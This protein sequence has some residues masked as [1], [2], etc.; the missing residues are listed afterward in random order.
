LGTP[1]TVVGQGATPLHST[2]LHWVGTHMGARSPRLQSPSLHS[3]PRHATPRHATPLQPGAAAARARR[4]WREPCVCAWAPA[5]SIVAGLEG[6][7]KAGEWSG[8]LIG[9]SAGCRAYLPKCSAST[10]KLEC[11]PALRAPPLRAGEP[12]PGHKL[13]RGRARRGW[14]LVS[15]GVSCAACWRGEGCPA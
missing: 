4:V 2:P 13:M 5:L 9:L 6:H 11:V 7:D 8:G 14:H 1:G 3:T 15:D 12:T 10:W